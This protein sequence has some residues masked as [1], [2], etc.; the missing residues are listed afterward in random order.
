MAYA[1]NVPPTPIPNPGTSPQG[2]GEPAYD[3][4]NY[5]P[6]LSAPWQA[7]EAMGAAYDDWIRERT[8]EMAKTFVPQLLRNLV[9]LAN[10]ITRHHATL[11]ANLT[12]GQMACLD[13]IVTS[14]NTC[15]TGQAYRE[16][17]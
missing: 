14:I 6:Y 12:T 10:Y 2:L 16:Q 8:Q 3:A 5:W 17:P 11:A 4:H 9:K 13:S 7:Y 1:G 15:V